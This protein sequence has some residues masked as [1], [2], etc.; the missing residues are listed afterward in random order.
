MVRVRGEPFSPQVFSPL[1]CPRLLN[2]A[3]PRNT[4]E[5]ARG[6]FTSRELLSGTRQKICDL[7]LVLNA[8]DIPNRRVITTFRQPDGLRSAVHVS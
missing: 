8:M 4:V 7:F 3:R 1:R 2:R 6:S 5:L